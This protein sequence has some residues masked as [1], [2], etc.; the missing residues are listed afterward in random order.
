MAIS[1]FH[2]RDLTTL[3]NTA[4]GCVA[5]SASPIETQQAEPWV[6]KYLAEQ[7]RLTSLP[8]LL[9][10]HMSEKGIDPR[11]FCCP[12]S[13]PAAQLAEAA[14]AGINETR[15]GRVQNTPPHS[16]GSGFLL[17]EKLPQQDADTHRARASTFDKPLRD[18]RLPTFA[19][20]VNRSLQV[21]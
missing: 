7:L 4:I 8:E 2:Q 21:N 12:V 9:G 20:V 1:R 17:F 18:L 6:E 14:S 11:A 16:L 19:P 13:S 3:G 5:S 15:A 10:A